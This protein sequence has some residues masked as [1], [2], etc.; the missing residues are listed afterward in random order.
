MLFHKDRKSF[1]LLGPGGCQG[2]KLM[3]IKYE[4]LQEQLNTYAIK[5]ALTK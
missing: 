4:K 3:F 2:D 5:V 1:T